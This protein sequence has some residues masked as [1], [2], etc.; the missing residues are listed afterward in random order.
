MPAVPAGASPLPRSL[1]RL[2]ACL[3]LVALVSLLGGATTAPQIP[4]WYTTLSKPAWTP[5]NAVFPIAWT[6]LYLMMAVC[7]WRLWDKVPPSPARHRAI[8]LFLLQLALNAIWSPVFFG[9]HAIWPGLLII[10]TLLVALLAT[11]RACFRVD[12]L[13][14]WL[15]VPYLI[16][17]C[18]AAS[19]NA[20]IAVLN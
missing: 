7:L 5:P 9:L 10:L 15:L 2:L 16:W 3:A 11:L 17:G 8:L 18:Y 12:A 6:L 4:T 19:L 20:A 14:G 13:A 1:L